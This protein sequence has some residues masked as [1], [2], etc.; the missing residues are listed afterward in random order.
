[1]AQIVIRN[2]PDHVMDAFRKLTKRRGTSLEQE[3]RDL[4]ANAVTQDTR[5]RRFRTAS[6]RQMNRFREEG[7][8]FSDSADLIRE[9]RERF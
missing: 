2:I 8:T 4:I 1:M 6:Q 5:L 3:V 7:R 9:D